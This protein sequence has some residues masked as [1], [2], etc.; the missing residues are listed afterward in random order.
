MINYWIIPISAL[1]VGC[2]IAAGSIDHKV[3]TIWPA[4][5]IEMDEMKSMSCHELRDKNSHAKY[6][7]SDNG[8]YARD[9]IKSC[10][11]A[12][13]EIA[14]L[15]LD[16]LNLLLADPNSIQ[17]LKKNLAELI[18][19][20]NEKHPLLLD[21]QNKTKIL[22]NELNENDEKITELSEKLIELGLVEIKNN[23]FD[24][25]FTDVFGMQYCIPTQ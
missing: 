5:A 10:E 14:K 19:T 20:Y 17:S 11:D 23:C 12:E 9:V 4:A 3:N 13:A 25:D 16:R 6:W 1:I 18:S 21:Y 7:T 22:T 8:K 15:E 2:A 24:L